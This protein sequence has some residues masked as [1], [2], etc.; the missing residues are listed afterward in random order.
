LPGNSWECLVQPAKRIKK[1]YEIDFGQFQGVITEE[2]DTQRRVITFKPGVD[3]LSRL[4]DQGQVPL[5]PYIK[6]KLDKDADMDYLTRRY[7]TV[8]AKNDGA[9]AAPTAGLHFTPELLEKIKGK[10]V[11][12]CYITLHTGAGT[13]KPVFAEFVDEHKMF[14]EEYEIGEETAEALRLPLDKLGV[15]QGKVVAVGTTVTRALEDC[16]SKHGKIVA[17]KDEAEIFI[18]PPY[19][20]NVISAMVTNFHFPK[21]TLLMMISAFAGKDFIF[22][23]YKEA[24]KQKYRFYSFGDAMMIA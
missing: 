3:V 5:P 14:A 8:Y 4:K 22:A 6:E 18:Y 7:Q 23:A 1:G 21:S 9:S 11:T 15:A 24:V 12:I 17:C 19:K 16:F 10:G 13:F 2:P 20:F